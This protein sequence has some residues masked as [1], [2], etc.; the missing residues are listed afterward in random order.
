M[1]PGASKQTTAGIGDDVPSKRI[2]H[3][4]RRRFESSSSSL[5]IL[6]LRFLWSDCSPPVLMH[7]PMTTMSLWA[8]QLW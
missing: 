8:G 6:L 2:L 1:L 5:S 4:F 3:S 7:D